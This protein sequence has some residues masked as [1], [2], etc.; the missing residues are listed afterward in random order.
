MHTRDGELELD[1]W[2]GDRMDYRGWGG[3]GRRE[4]GETGGRKREGGSDNDDDND[5]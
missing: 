1:N 3:L 2:A 5:D 4:G